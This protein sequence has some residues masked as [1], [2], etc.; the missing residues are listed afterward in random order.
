MTHPFGGG[1]VDNLVKCIFDALQNVRV[2]GDDKTVTDMTVSKRF[3][4]A[5]HP[6]GVQVTLTGW[7]D[8]E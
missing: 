5:D 6:E 2:I 8:P 4:D 3:A 1:D 7:L